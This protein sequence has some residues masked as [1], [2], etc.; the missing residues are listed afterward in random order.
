ML[1]CT[2]FSFL[3]TT[4]ENIVGLNVNIIDTAVPVAKEVKNKLQSNNLEN[5][6][7]TKG[8]VEFWVS[9]NSAQASESINELWEKDVKVSSIQQITPT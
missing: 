8:I 9:G 2:H 3:K 4:I 5:T 7:N 1:G 6:E